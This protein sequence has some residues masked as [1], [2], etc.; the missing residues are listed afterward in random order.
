MDAPTFKDR[1]WDARIAGNT[2]LEAKQKEP[3]RGAPSDE[4]SPTTKSRKS[5][6]PKDDKSHF[7]TTG[8]VQ[9]GAGISVSPIEVI[10]LTMTNKAG[11]EGNKDRGMAP[12]AWRVVQHAVYV[13][14]FFV[15]PTA[16]RKSGCD[17]KDVD[18]LKFVVPHAYRHTASAVRP[19]VEV[20][21]AWYTVTARFV[22]GSLR[23]VVGG[24]SIGG[25]GRASGAF[26]P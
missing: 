26:G 9:F 20:L 13:M 24:V 21:H 10:R 22:R 19:F 3:A 2:F 16:A 5:K 6:G 8:V 23:Q 1:Y 25:R 12:L 11:V 14:P 15:N 7:I 17:A 4:P 18:L